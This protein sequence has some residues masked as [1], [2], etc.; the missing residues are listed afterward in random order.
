MLLIGCLGGALAP[1]AVLFIHG[2]FELLAVGLFIGWL[3]GGAAGPLYVA[4]IPTESISP[5]LSATAVAFSLAF[6]EII[7]G[8]IAPAAAGRVADATSLAAPFWISFACALISAVLTLFLTETAPRKTA[9]SGPIPLSK[10][11]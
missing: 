3:I 7:G 6:G 4:I 2:S 5:A 8:V 10:A 9:S 1:L 11:A